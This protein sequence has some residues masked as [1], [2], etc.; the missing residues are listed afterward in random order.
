M[1]VLFEI[2]ISFFKVGMF[3]FGGGLAAL[4]L[5]AE[6]LVTNRAWLTMSELTDL[7]SIAQMT[8]GP[9]AINSSTFV[10]LRLAGAPGAIVA[11]LG[12]IVPSIIYITILYKLY[13]KYNNL[14]I[15]QTILKY[16]RAAIIAL[17]ASAGLKIFINVIDL[18][19]AINYI[20]IVMFVISFI[21]IRKTKLSPVKIMMSC[22]IIGII[23][24][25]IL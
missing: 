25:S 16:L 2:F 21:A 20:G 22:G 7:V 14:A 24:F 1:N 6:E 3:S 10:G 8:P 5:I 13:K 19:G 18:D 23:V 15:M 11:T 17:I 4:P 12:C 9:I